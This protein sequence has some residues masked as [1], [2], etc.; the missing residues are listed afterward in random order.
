MIP[1]PACASARRIVAALGLTA[2]IV[3]LELARAEARGRSVGASMLIA[4][5]SAAYDRGLADGLAQVYPPP[6]PAG[7]MHDPEAGVELGRE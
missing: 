3:K 2:V 7:L 1:C 4:A 6:W 5:R